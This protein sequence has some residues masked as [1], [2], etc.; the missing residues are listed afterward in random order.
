MEELDEI[1]KDGEK[2][3][4]VEASSLPLERAIQSQLG[5]IQRRSNPMLST[6]IS[7]LQKKG[8]ILPKKRSREIN[9]AHHKLTSDVI[10]RLQL[11]RYLQFQKW[12][13]TEHI[14]WNRVQT[15]IERLA[16]LEDFLFPLAGRCI[17]SIRKRL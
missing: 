6:R 4:E 13:C 8:K 12:I 7:I 3:G 5:N 1:L 14:D 11:Y 17:N 2:R 10:V 15:K 16:K 9:Y